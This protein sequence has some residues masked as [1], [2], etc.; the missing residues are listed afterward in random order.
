MHLLKTSVTMCVVYYYDTCCWQ[1]T[2]IGCL[3]KLNEEWN[4]EMELAMLLPKLL[5]FIWHHT[6]TMS[7]SLMFYRVCSIEVN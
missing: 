1:H 5:L 4:S 2:L 6:K 7:L 3:C